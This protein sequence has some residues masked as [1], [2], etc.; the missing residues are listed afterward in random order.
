M[1]P[2]VFLVLCAGVLAAGMAWLYQPLMTMRQ[3]S[4]RLAQLRMK[5]AALEQE[6]AGLEAYKEEAATEAGREAEARRQG[7][8]RKDERRI[9]FFR[10]KAPEAEGTEDGTGPTP[11]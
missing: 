7:Y 1:R 5:K 4:D 10:E 8:L 3:G 11:E 6:E 2:G 9:V